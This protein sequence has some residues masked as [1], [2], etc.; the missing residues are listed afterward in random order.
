MLILLICIGISNVLN[1]FI[2]MVPIPLIQIALG[3]LLAVL[4]LGIHMPL[5]PELFLVLFIAPLL[6]NDGKRV[7]RNELWNQRI[8]ILLM[9]LGLVFVTV[10]VLG[11]VIHLM[12][13]SISLSASFALAAIL[14]PTDAVAVQSL[15]KRIN[16][17]G[18]I[19]HLLEGEALTN[20]ASGL[21]AF[22]FAVAATVSGIFSLTQATFSFFLIAIGGVLAGVILSFLV[23]KLRRFIRRLGME[24]VTVQMLIQIITPFFLYLA[25]EELGG[26]GILAVVAGGIV[27]AYEHERTES[28]MSKLQVVSVSTWSVIIFILNGLVF[29]I[30]GLQI[31]AVIKVIFY[32]EKYDNLTVF[33]YILAISV[34]L[35]IIRFI[36]VYIFYEGK[37]TFS[38]KEMF[39]KT[40]LKFSVLTSISGVRGS[41]TLAA[42]FSIPY[43]ILGGNAFPQR[44]L[45]I[46]ISAG[47]ILFTLIEA[48][49]LLPLLSKKEKHINKENTDKLEHLALIKVIEAS[50]KVLRDEMNDENRK[51]TMYVISNFNKLIRNGYRNTNKF[52]LTMELSEIKK[53]VFTEALEAE[54][55][56]IEHLFE[57]DQVSR[58]VY[59]ELVELYS[60]TETI[61][62]DGFK[63]RFKLAVSTA[64][65]LVSK[66]LSLRKK[67]NLSL[68]KEVELAQITVYKG[69]IIAIRDKINEENK[70]A[71]I[72]LISHYNELIAR[73]HRGDLPNNLDQF[74]EIKRKLQFKAIEV[75]RKEVQLLFENGEI[76]RDI[77][78]KLRK[79][80]NYWEASILD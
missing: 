45:I 41:V 27:H 28:F 23:I 5:N 74:N 42:A 19:M 57:T 52:K 72:E 68:I 31:P 56:E 38:R 13:P 25:A 60:H 1:R 12:I 15:S 30:L 46:F 16:L 61:L 80:I 77:A 44:D 6:F 18:N 36:W 34:I 8:P 51:A 50:V 24:D 10:F 22:K 62:K 9:S 54:K 63:H 21:V 26:S 20:D 2:P 58:Q 14:S 7:S 59:F 4:P 49:V 79:F 43:V 32:D 35:I 55:K 76:N 11:Y 78:N 37:F 69:V 71:S 53:D 39:S 65:R 33:G 47:V 66:L 17:P 48:S 40:R 3:M 64:K 75:Q 29:L 70:A 73:L 67:S